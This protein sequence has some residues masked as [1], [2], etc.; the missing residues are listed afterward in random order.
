MA[1]PYYCVVSLS[2]LKHVQVSHYFFSSLDSYLG[3]KGRQLASNAR[4]MPSTLCALCHIINLSEP[5]FLMVRQ[6]ESNLM[7]SV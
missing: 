5:L 3:F 7:E 4:T 6:G 2:L 1:P